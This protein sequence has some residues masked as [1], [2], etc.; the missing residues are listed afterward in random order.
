LERLNLL[1]VTILT[2]TKA[3][4]IQETGLLVRSDDGTKQLLPA[5]TIIMSTGAVCNQALYQQLSGKVAEIYRVGDCAEPRRI[6]EATT[7]GFLASQ[8]I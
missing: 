6:L 4:A 3:E 8:A 7:E 5:D 2:K 1:R